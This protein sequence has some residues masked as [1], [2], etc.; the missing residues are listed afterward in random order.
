MAT[1]HVDLQC[2]LF[3]NHGKEVLLRLS[4]MVT[5]ERYVYQST[6]VAKIDLKTQKHSKIVLFSLGC[7]LFVAMVTR[8]TNLQIVL[9]LN[10]DIQEFIFKYDDGRYLYQS[11]KVAKIELKTPQKSKS[12][13]LIW[14]CY[15]CCHGN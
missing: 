2:V 3:L 11:T 1:R 9:F 10:H 14:L 12:M 15:I 13:F 6:T 7:V 8:Y 5:G 4:L